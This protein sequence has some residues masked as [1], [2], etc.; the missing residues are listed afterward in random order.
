VN[1]R[2]GALA[3][4]GAALRRREVRDGKGLG[5][6]AMIDLLSGCVRVS[7]GRNGLTVGLAVDV[8]GV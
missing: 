7:V 5:G 8:I 4:V 1:N 3:W 2:L 6:L